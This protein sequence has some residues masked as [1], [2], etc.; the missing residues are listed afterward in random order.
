M[1]YKSSVP[2]FLLT[3][4]LLQLS[5][6]P[7]VLSNNFDQTY[8][9][10]FKYGLLDQK[11]HVSVPPSLYEYY[12]NQTPNPTKDADYAK[13]VTPQAFNSM[14]ENIKTFIG[15]KTRSEEQFAN[16]V[17][18][19]VHQI[20]YG[21]NGAKYPIETI[22][23]ELGKC[24]T[25]S[26]LAASI[27]KAGGLDVVL[28]YFK[29]VHHINIGVY[30]PYQPYGT[31]WWQQPASY[32][33]E[34]KKYYIAE[35]TPAMDWKVGD[36]PPLLQGQIPT[37]ISLENTET[38]SPA[39]VSS[40]LGNPLNSSK[41]SINLSSAASNINNPDHTLNVFGSIKPPYPNQTITLYTSQD[42]IIYNT[43][44]TK[45]DQSGNYSINWNTKSTGTHYIRASW[46]GNS[47]NTPADSETMTLFLGFP[48]SLIQFETQNYYYMYGYPGFGSYFLGVR[49][50][51]EEFLNIQL[52]ANGATLSGEFFVFKSGQMITI[53]ETGKIPINI[54]KINIPKGLQPLR[55]P[56]DIEE[57]T[58]DQFGFI[59]KNHNNNY[60]LNMRSLDDNEII[61]SH[62]QDETKKIFM[63]TSKQ[64]QEN[65]WY[66]VEALISEIE[67]TASIRD[68]YGNLVEKITQTKTKEQTINELQILLT[69]NTDKAIAFKNLRFEPLSETLQ[70]KN[71]PPEP[72]L[73]LPKYT[74]FVLLLSIALI[75]TIYT[76]K[77]IQKKKK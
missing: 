32:E 14:A 74:I 62:N 60:T 1:H 43:L 13:L 22:V 26:V 24:D 54:T 9:F 3:I 61:L 59:L 58:N 56:Q 63:N 12:H 36:V 57:T 15:N 53:P 45:T 34:G 42:G 70:E 75:G 71:N 28:L 64:I 46:S 29:G 50:G 8:S 16:A 7:P 4:I 40:Q 41:I 55:L 10:Q 23:E 69:N 44:D 25:L 33:F 31:W 77:R 66:T 37:I 73:H 6:V 27:M 47:E 76:K 2:G 35:C 51:V 52:L 21:D 20:E 18:T 67:I 38:P 68:E 39:Q 48:N 11:I 17:L 49:Q 30:L 19:L 72:Y 65:K 5:I